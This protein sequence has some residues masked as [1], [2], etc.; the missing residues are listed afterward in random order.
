AYTAHLTS[1]SRWGE[2]VEEAL[3]AFE[4]QDQEDFAHQLASIRA[5]I[6]RA[7]L[8]EDLAS[9]LAAAYR[10]EAVVVRPSP[11]EPR[12]PLELPAP[13]LGISGAVELAR[14]IRQVWALAWTPQAVAARLRRAGDVGFTL[15]LLVQRLIG[16]EVSGGLD[17]FDP[18][19]GN[20]HRLAL[21]AVAG[22]GE[23]VQHD[24]VAAERYLIEKAGRRV[25]AYTPLT[26]RRVL[27][28]GSQLEWVE[29]KL[30]VPLLDEARRN[31]LLDMGR[32]MEQN[33]G[34]AQ[35]LAWTLA[36]QELYVLAAAPLEL[37]EGDWPAEGRNV[38][39]YPDPLTPL[40]GSL[41]APAFEL[42]SVRAAQE[43]GLPS[44]GYR[45]EIQGGY[46]FEQEREPVA[47][48]RGG[49]SE[50]R[51][52]TLAT[53][54]PREWATRF[55]PLLAAETR[56]P[57]EQS[58]LEWYH[59]VVERF[60]LEQYQAFQVERALA[61]LRFRAESIY[62]E[63]ADPEGQGFALHLMGLP[64]RSVNMV[65]ALYTLA[66]ESA[67]LPQV[68]SVLEAAPRPLDE[69][70]KFPE[71]KYWLEGFRGFLR[72]FGDLSLAAWDLGLPVLAE[73]PAPLLRAVRL[74][75]QGPPRLALPRPPALPGRSWARRRLRAVL[76]PLRRTWPI[77]EERE[78]L[79]FSSQARLRR[80]LLAV[81]RSLVEARLIEAIGDVFYLE[82]SELEAVL[83]GADGSH[84]RQVVRA[85]RCRHQE[86]YASPP[87]PGPQRPRG[88]SSGRARGRA[89]VVRSPQDLLSLEPGEVLVCRSTFAAWS[90]LL[91]FA[92]G[93]VLEA[94]DELGHGATLAREFGVPAV[95]GYAGAV[96][97]I[98]PGAPLEVDGDQ[99]WVRIGTGSAS[100][101]KGK[102]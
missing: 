62:R 36:G 13:L 17:T 39:L 11:A 73:D 28:A 48:P 102:A 24:G 69:L 4:A 46:W 94:E 98:D 38:E 96:A 61:F 71:G 78:H 51:L 56:A 50:R 10:G 68:R 82:A 89:R 47:L 2:L 43:L 70:A 42:A 99:A 55:K 65:R 18:F 19:T 6:E 95:V 79:L 57:Q 67:S 22:M 100:G 15:P 34:G 5:Q 75:Q 58:L 54:L 26:Q 60:Q 8:Q 32:W 7:P 81:G 88:A 1:I 66:E 80:G 16:G 59:R 85:R 27:R 63:V 76:E 86:Q 84:F 44:G 93:L 90:P 87:P 52:K 3:S 41:A 9:Q 35:R 33:L 91:P 101:W 83:S 97:S 53:N 31:L 64:N 37:Q 49:A 29:E 92:N 74:F 12:D 20:P 14:A 23:G 45:V 72:Q 30:A 40:G 21:W 77:K 25:V